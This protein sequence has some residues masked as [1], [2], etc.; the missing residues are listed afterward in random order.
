LKNWH[1][2]IP[3]FSIGV[4]L[5]CLVKLI[6]IVKRAKSAPFIACFFKSQ[7]GSIFSLVFDEK[8]STLFLDLLKIFV[9]WL[10]CRRGLAG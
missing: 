8:I 2:K 5:I 9:L 1:K 3:Y 10:R 4:R 6:L 7:G